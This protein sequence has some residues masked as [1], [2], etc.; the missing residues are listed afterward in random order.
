[1][2]IVTLNLFFALRGLRK[3]LTANGLMDKIFRDM[4]ITG[5]LHEKSS[6]QFRAC[7]SLWVVDIKSPL[8]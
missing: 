6:Y 7:N 2:T 8:R 3:L 5:S 4:T 1:L